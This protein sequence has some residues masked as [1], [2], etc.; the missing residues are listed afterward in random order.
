MNDS[1]AYR[2]VLYFAL[3]LQADGSHGLVQTL[4]DPRE[5]NEDL[6]SQARS[7][8]DRFSQLLNPVADWWFSGSAVKCYAD[9]M[10]PQGPSYA[11]SKEVVAEAVAELA[12]L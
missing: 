8:A 7:V 2:T 6:F 9:G 4:F 1:N 10:R 11:M 5:L 3:G 12:V